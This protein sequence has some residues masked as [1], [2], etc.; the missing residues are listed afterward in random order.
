MDTSIKT[1]IA[2][3]QS[4]QLPHWVDLP[5]IDLY[6]EQ[7]ITY[8]NN[9]LSQVFIDHSKQNDSYISASM[10]NNYVKQGIMIPPVKKKYRRTHI[11]FIITITILKQIGSLNDVKKGIYHLKSVYGKVDAYNYFID[12][13][14]QAL[15]VAASELL[16]SPDPSYYSEAVAIDLLPL[17]TATIAFASIMLSRYLFS[18]I[19]ISVEGDKK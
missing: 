19:D 13:L 3:I 10:I 6:S 7:V 16:H 15:R 1:W 17:K 12:Y 18:K 8:V 9:Q 2:K 14:Q 5:D 4:I 11:A